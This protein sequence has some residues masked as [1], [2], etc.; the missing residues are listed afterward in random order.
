MGPALGSSSTISEGSSVLSKFRV[1]EK[2]FRVRE[3]PKFILRPLALK[4][5]I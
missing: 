1:R 5:L 4:D 2:K 3:K